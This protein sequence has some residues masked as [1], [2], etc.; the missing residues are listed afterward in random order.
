MIAKLSDGCVRDA[1]KYLDQI[2][3]MG[4]VTAASVGQF[5]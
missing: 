2:S 4:E 1:N 5:L 3:V